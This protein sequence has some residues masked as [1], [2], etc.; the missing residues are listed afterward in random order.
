MRACALGSKDLSGFYKDHWLIDSGA[1]D[2]IMPYLEDFSNLAQGEQFASTAKGSIIKMHG[3]LQFSSWAV[4]FSSSHPFVPHL[5]SWGPFLMLIIT[6][7]LS[8][9]TSHSPYAPSNPYTVP[10]I[11]AGQGI[12]FAYHFLVMDTY[13][14]SQFSHIAAYPSYIGIASSDQV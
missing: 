4:L 7:F 6:I 10:C 1:S 8:W 2:H 3:L 5:L 9:D 13:S 11:T 12:P 14:S